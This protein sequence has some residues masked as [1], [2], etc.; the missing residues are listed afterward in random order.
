MANFIDP[1]N[2]TFYAQE[3]LI[4]LENALGMAGRV[5]RGYDSERKSA[6]LGDTIQISKPGTFSTQAGGTGTASDLN[7]TKLDLT[8]DTWREVKFAIDDDDLAFTGERI[9]QDHISPAV[10]AIANYIETQLTAEYLNVPWSY[11][12]GSTP[13]SG[14][15]VDCRKVLRDN[16]GSLVDSDVV[17]F[18]IDSTLEGAFL[19]LSLFHAANVAGEADSQASRRRGSLGTRFGIEHFVQQTLTNHT[20]GTVVSAE[21]DVIG[22][23]SADG[24]ERDTT[25][26]LDS[27][28]GTETL[29]AGDSF[30]IAGNTQRYVVT[31][32]TT[33]ATGA[34]TSVPIYPALITDYTSGDAV[35]FETISSS[36]WADRYFA[37]IMFHKNAFAIALA[38]LPKVGDGAGA[39]MDVITDPRTGLS[40]R[41]RVAYDDDNAKVKVTLDVLFG[42]K[43]LDPNLAVVARRN[44]A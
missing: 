19:N 35:T 27:L 25:I 29:A 30:I 22:A 16:A 38:P 15:I 43:T 40:I 39:R 41:S 42:I 13:D 11:D 2:P 32:A 18:A 28:N 36:V 1:Y 10:Y 12:I 14:D 21:N 7:P 44:Y 3:A 33:L 23:L 8:V 34:N 24:D 4:V 6:N 5:H 37:N 17:H 26:A 31:A 9:I 20:S